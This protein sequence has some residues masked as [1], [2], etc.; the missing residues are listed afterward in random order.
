MGRRACLTCRYET[1][2]GYQCIPM[3]FHG[4]FDDTVSME[5]K[6]SLQPTK[7]FLVEDFAPIRERLAALV[8]TV[9]GA[10]VVGNADEPA[11]ALAAIDLCQPD[12]VVLDLRLKAGTSGLT[13][14]KGLTERTTGAV[15]IVLTNTTYAQLRQVCMNLGARFFFDKSSEFTSVR[16]VVQQIVDD[17][18]CGLS[19]P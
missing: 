10:E 17:R 2:Q 15:V 7:V 9:L 1:G 3:F 4:R 19:A 14:L 6:P 11:S 5:Y 16:D 13:V 18:R 8:Q 12:V